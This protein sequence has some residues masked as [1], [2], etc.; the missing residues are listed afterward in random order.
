MQNDSR[1]TSTFLSGMSPF[2][3]DK[4]VKAK[5]LKQILCKDDQQEVEEEHIPSRKESSSRKSGDG[6]KKRKSDDKS[7]KLKTPPG[8]KKSDATAK[9]PAIQDPEARA[10]YMK[11]VAT[12]MLSKF[13]VNIPFDDDS[14]PPS[15]IDLDGAKFNTLRKSSILL[16]GSGIQMQSTRARIAK[17]ILSTDIFEPPK[18]E[19]STRLTEELKTSNSSS[20]AGSGNTT[21]K[22]SPKS[23]DSIKIDKE[24]SH[25]DKHETDKKRTDKSRTKEKSSKSKEKAAKEKEKEKAEKER[26]E[27]EKVAKEKAEKVIK[28]KA[29]KE[30]AEKEKV[31]KEKAEKERLEKEKNDKKVRGSSKNVEKKVHISAEYAYDQIKLQKDQDRNSKH[32]RASSV[33]V[34]ISEETKTDPSPPKLNLNMVNRLSTLTDIFHSP[35][36]D[37]LKFKQSPFLSPHAESHE[38]TAKDKLELQKPESPRKAAQITPRKGGSIKIKVDIEDG[39]V[40]KSLTTDNLATFEPLKSPSP[41]KLETPATPEVRKEKRDEKRIHRHRREHSD[42]T[43]MKEK[44]TEGDL[45]IKLQKEK[46]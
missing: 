16:G 42:V 31:A 1:S 36:S 26:L 35:R 34:P 14:E 21:S 17:P 9:K 13:L 45:L 39:K 40:K 37:D 20:S 4:V 41:T 29:E 3:Q 43:G 46:N 30:K 27:K 33:S 8:R 12:R 28:E 25:K 19:E 23:K 2:K 15:D 22:D 24:K 32:R 10:E 7:D 44:N 11:K 5:S 38:L 6:V 18:P